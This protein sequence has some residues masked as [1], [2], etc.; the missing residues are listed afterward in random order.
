MNV[1]RPG[2]MS[3]TAAADSQRMNFDSRNEQA[4][5]RRTEVD[6]VMIGDSTVRFWDVNLYFRHTGKKLLN[7]GIEGDT[8]HFIARRFM[9][10]VV[11]LH[12]KKC[13]YLAGAAELA[14]LEENIWVSDPALPEETVMERI[15]TGIREAS[16][17][18]ARNGISMI[19]CSLLPDGRYP[20]MIRKINKSLE[21][22]CQNLQIQYLDL[23]EEF[24]DE[25]GHM[26]RELGDDFGV[27]NPAGYLELTKRVEPL[28]VIFHRS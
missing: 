25:S 10:D 22:L 27:L 23:Y 17:I 16:D 9:A 20:D 5:L 7:R 28:I 14:G 13:F 19:F 21:L 11:Q 3:V 24:A 2:S 15:M 4:L 6:C 1:I 12:P 26:K 8:P 18:A